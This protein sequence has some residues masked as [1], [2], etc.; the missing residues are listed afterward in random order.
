MLASTVEFSTHAITHTHAPK[1]IRKQTYVGTQDLDI[2]DLNTWCRMKYCFV[3]L[4]KKLYFVHYIKYC[5][6]FE[7]C[8]EF[9]EMK[10]VS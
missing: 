6:C 1:H 3:A 10:D 4:P 7:L 2:A 5:I 9:D 8:F